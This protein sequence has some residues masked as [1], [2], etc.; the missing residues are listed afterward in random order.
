MLAC[1]PALKVLVS[2]IYACQRACHEIAR[3]SGAHALATPHMPLYV[4]HGRCA[5]PRGAHYS[6][7]PQSS[8]ANALAAGVPAL[9][10]QASR[11]PHRGAAVRHQALPQ[12][13]ACT[14]VRT[15]AFGAFCC[16]RRMP[17]HRCSGALMD[18]GTSGSAPLRDLG[19]WHH[20]TPLSV[21]HSVTVCPS[22]AGALGR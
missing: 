11:L 18:N 7:T 21:I 14:R 19:M 3:P 15:Q 16:S 1:I 4:P 22:P 20:A 5:C 13:R 6:P 17:C 9:Q 2:S 8:R 12:V 10:A